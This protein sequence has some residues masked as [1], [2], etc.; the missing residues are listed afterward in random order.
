MHVSGDRLETDRRD[1]ELTPGGA[2]TEKPERYK[3]RPL[4]SRGKRGN[5][6]GAERLHP[7]AGDGKM[8]RIT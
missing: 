2:Y 7:F 5:C 3:S 1:G 8:D 6:A 4:R